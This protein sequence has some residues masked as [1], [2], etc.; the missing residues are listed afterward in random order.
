MAY[1]LKA[2]LEADGAAVAMT[3]TDDSYKENSDR[4]TFCNA[5]QATILV[6][7]HTNS[8]SDPVLGW[9]AGALLSPARG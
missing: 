5:E 1:G 3:R 4:Y 8:V 7:V 6:S 2:L 9:F